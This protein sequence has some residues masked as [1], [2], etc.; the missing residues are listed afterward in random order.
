MFKIMR[1]KDAHA[2]TASVKLQLISL[3]CSKLTGISPLSADHT[4]AEH[5]AALSVG[6]S[7]RKWKELGLAVLHSG[8]AAGSAW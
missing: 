6:E 8:L 4:R 3:F 5:R 1:G 7:H 2:K